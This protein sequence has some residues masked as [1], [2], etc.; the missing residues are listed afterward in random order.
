[1]NF[2]PPAFAFRFSIAN[3]VGDMRLLNHSFDCVRDHNIFRAIL[4]NGQ[5]SPHMI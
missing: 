3:P 5:N 4:K 2:T 1:V